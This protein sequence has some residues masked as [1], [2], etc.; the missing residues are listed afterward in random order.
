MPSSITITKTEYINLVETMRK[1]LNTTTHGKNFST[2]T[3]QDIVSTSLGFANHHE[4]LA[5][6][7]KT[8]TDKDSN[9]FLFKKNFYSYLSAQ[10]KSDDIWGS[11][12][13]LLAETILMIADYRNYKL[14]QRSI[15]RLLTLDS[16]IEIHKSDK[17]PENIKAQILRYFETLVGFTTIRKMKGNDVI[18]QQHILN[19]PY[20]LISC[21]MNK[22]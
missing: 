2:E 17:T 1:K 20:I 13:L 14:S 15:E 5:Y 8:Q 10:I 12:I 6:F 18:Q 4:V 22:K 11:R 16:L 3:I 7:A 21:K 19:I 9:N